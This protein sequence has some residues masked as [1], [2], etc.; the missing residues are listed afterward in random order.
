VKIDADKQKER[1]DMGE[2]QKG[3]KLPTQKGFILNASDVVPMNH[4]ENVKILDEKGKIQ[5]AKRENGNPNVGLSV[6]YPLLCTENEFIKQ[7]PEP[8]LFTTVTLNVIQPGGGQGLHYYE[9][10]AENPVFDV[11]IHVISGQMHVT[12]GDIEKTVGMDTF[13]YCPSNV[14]YS[15]IN[16]G[17]EKAEILTMTASVRGAKRGK[18]V[19]LN[20]LTRKAGTQ[21]KQ[22]NDSVGDKKGFVLPTQ[23][24]FIVHATEITPTKPNESVLV[25]DEK[26]KIQTVKSKGGPELLL[27]YPLLRP[28]VAFTKQQPEPSLCTTVTL[29]MPQPGGHVEEHYYEYSEEMPAFDM[30]NYIISGQMHITIGDIEKTVGAGTLI[31]WPSNVRM[32]GI[33]VG[34]DVAKYI[35]VS[36]TGGGTIGKPVYPKRPT[37]S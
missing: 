5:T 29:H 1:I 7:Q 15:L 4:S 11:A 33:N 32:S 30:A 22:G 27:F 26:G 12:V 18:P 16:V 36:G 2:Y 28:I 20:M 34:K 37:W 3:L 6:D 8:S 23:K 14:K 24:G 13:I 19:Y 9:Y 17:K 31:Y 25:L 35:R 21:D 10:N